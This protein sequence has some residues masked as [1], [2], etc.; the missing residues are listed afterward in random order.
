MPIKKNDLRKL[1][2]SSTSGAQCLLC[3]LEQHFN[4][5]SARDENSLICKHGSLEKVAHNELPHLDFLKICRR[6]FCR[7]LFGS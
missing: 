5:L 1:E 3:Y 2:L 7:L 6:K 4:S